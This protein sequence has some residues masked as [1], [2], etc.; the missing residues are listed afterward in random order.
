MTPAS[1]FQLF[2][3]SHM[4]RTKF[5]RKKAKMQKRNLAV[6][7]RNIYLPGFQRGQSS[8]IIQ[9]YISEL[10]FLSFKRAKK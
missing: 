7:T 3:R 9:R 4:Q 8:S 1:I 5:F 6:S 2:L 10:S